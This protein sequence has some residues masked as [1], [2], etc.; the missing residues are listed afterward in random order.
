M[1]NYLI[2]IFDSTSEDGIEGDADDK[3]S[4][5]SGKVINEKANNE[6]S[7]SEPLR[8]ILISGHYIIFDS[9]KK[10]LNV[11]EEW[12]TDGFTQW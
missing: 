2:A 7:I 6:E 3:Q 10:R 9:E 8:I 11:R 4:D 12:S 1:F 5:G